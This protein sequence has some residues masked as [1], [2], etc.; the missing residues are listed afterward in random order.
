LYGLPYDAEAN[1]KWLAS[2]YPHA[3][4]YV[5]ADK[6][7]IE[8]LKEAI[9]DNMREVISDKN[10]THKVGYLQHCNSFKNAGDFYSALK[11]ILEVTTAQDT[12]ARGV[13][14]DFLIQNINFFRKE[15]E[16]LFLVKDFPDLAV[17]LICHEDLESEA[18]GLWMCIEQD[19]GINIPSCSK[20]KFLFEAHFLRRY[21]YDD[22]WEC[23][24]CRVVDKPAC[25]DCRAE[26]VWVSDSDC[27]KAEQESGEGNAMDVDDDSDAAAKAS[28][29]HA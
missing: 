18:E 17:E 29:E 7:Q 8:P 24:K 11:T 15:N 12:Q 16:F 14:L 10:Y 1:S 22:L 21:R 5:A 3:Q 20:C 9:A 4:V 19:C 13:L 2:L 26:I 28:R 23:P 25:V 27:A 6:Y